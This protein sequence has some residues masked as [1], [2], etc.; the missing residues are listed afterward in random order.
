MQ[1]STCSWNGSKYFVSFAYF[2][3]TINVNQLSCHT[4]THITFFFPT[5]CMCQSDRFIFRGEFRT[6]QKSRKP[7]KQ[8]HSAKP[9][10][11]PGNGMLKFKCRSVF[12]FYIVCFEC[13]QRRSRRFH[14]GVKYCD[15]IL[16]SKNKRRVIFKSNLFKK[17][18]FLYSRP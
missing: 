10:Y 16:H 17:P 13:E 8:N 7:A 4:W 12:C 11:R 5:N 1:R 6:L 3:F 18:Y 15:R 9:A 2:L 14:S